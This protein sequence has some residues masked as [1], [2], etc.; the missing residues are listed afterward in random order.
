MCSFGVARK[1][2]ICQSFSA[3]LFFVNLVYLVV[4]F[5]ECVVTLPLYLVQFLEILVCEFG[6]SNF[7]FL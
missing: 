4:L 2:G 7:Y 1:L 3:C 6:F 5:L